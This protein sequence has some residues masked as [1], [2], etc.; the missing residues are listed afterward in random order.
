M[1]P[2]FSIDGPSKEKL[3]PAMLFVWEGNDIVKTTREMIAAKNR[4]EVAAGTFQCSDSIKAANREIALA[5]TP[6]EMEESAKICRSKTFIANTELARQ[7]AKDR[8]LDSSTP[9]KESSRSAMRIAG[10]VAV[11]G[12]AIATGVIFA[13]R[14]TSK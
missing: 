11:V 13:K 10:I 6:F 9:K 14:Q 8:E 1:K 12:A 4:S 3:E 5:F 2:N 7:T